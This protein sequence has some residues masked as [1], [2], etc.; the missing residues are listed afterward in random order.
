MDASSEPGEAHP[1]EAGGACNR[2]RPL[3]KRWAMLALALVTLCGILYA[4]THVASLMESGIRYAASWLPFQGGLQ[5]AGDFQRNRKQ[6]DEVIALVRRDAL[7][8]V[9]TNRRLRQLPGQY[10]YLSNDGGEIVVE[11]PAG[12]SKVLFFSVRGMLSGSSGL[13]YTADDQPVMSGEGIRS[14][15]K[16]APNWYWVET[17]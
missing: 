1:G 14:A 4:A 11:D 2:S 10:R 13:L 5:T 9:A 8:P 6:L 7:A 12:N 16:Q 17:E 3:R 15:R